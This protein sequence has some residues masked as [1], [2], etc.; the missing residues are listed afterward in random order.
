[1]AKRRVSKTELE[2]A[3]R[4]VGADEATIAAIEAGP[5]EVELTTPT[6]DTHVFIDKYATGQ[7]VLE[8]A[9]EGFFRDRRIGTTRLENVQDGNGGYV[10]KMIPIVVE[11]VDDDPET[12]I[13]RYRIM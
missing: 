11:H 1:M 12:G 3:A 8:E 5:D 9:P 2:A 4:Q 7:Y 10:S 13:W 6:R